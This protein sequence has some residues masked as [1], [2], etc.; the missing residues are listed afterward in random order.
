MSTILLL[1]AVSLF[2]GD[3]NPENSKHLSLTSLTLPNL[4]YDTIDHRPGGGALSVAWSMG[5]IKKL[6]PTF[7][8]AGF[9]QDAFNLFGIGSGAI[10]TFTAYGVVRDKREGKALQGKAI[11]RGSIGKLTADAW[12]RGAEFGHDYRIDEVTKYQLWLGGQ[13]WY[14]IDFWV[15][16][17]PRVFGQTDAEYASMLGLV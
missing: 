11:F 6:E 14:S 8:L 2:L 9:D 17:R 1:E 7:K 3:A 15:N 12:T 13:E 4:E 16:P 10:N 5:V